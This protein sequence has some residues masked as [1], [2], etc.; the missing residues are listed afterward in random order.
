MPYLLPSTAPWVL[1]VRWALLVSLT[2]PA[3]ADVGAGEW[4][5]SA[6]VEVEA[7]MFPTAAAHPR[8]KDATFSP[9]ISIQPEAV[10]EWNDRDDRFTFKP[11]ARW[12]RDDPGRRHGD[13]R[14]ASWL[15]LGDGW[16]TVVG[17]DKVFWGV[18]ESRHLVDIINQ[19][20]AVENIDGEDKLGQ[21]MVSATVESDWGTASLFV[22]PWFRQRT[23]ADAEGR[24]S[25]PVAVDGDIATYDSGAE[26]RHLD[27][28]LRWAQ[29][30]GDLDV[31][32]AHF[33][34]TSREPRLISTT[35]NG[36]TVLVPHYDLIDQTSLDAQLTKDA[37]LWK[38][39]AISR[40]GHGRRF[41]AVVAG[42]EHTLY[43]V[44]G[45]RAD[46][47]LL[48]EYQYDGR[49]AATAPATAADDD[50]FVGA[51]L[52]LNDEQD[53][54]LLAGAV[55]D[56]STGSTLLSIEAERRLSDR[57]RVSLEGRFLINIDSRDP[58]AA[59]QNDDALTVRL[60]AYF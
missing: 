9:S 7:R 47:G 39:E 35:V 41:Y 54:S 55:V 11:F 28:A 2:L 27:F 23:F 14:E 38:L 10:Y 43:G 50:V 26:Q 3:A 37:T 16:D 6:V 48:A 57:F 1:A 44:A 52:T 32:V 34:G 29:T 18:T 15:H 59:I 22:L 5:V 30:F 12:D 36:T 19:T 31:G 49:Q 13:L 33:R 58:L 51:R 25:G 21:P 45:T 46:L 24:F 4:D 60:S 53:T 17:I 42:F 8:Q 56:R 40:S 20:D